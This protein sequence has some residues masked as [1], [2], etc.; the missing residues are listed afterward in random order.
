VA[1]NHFIFTWFNGEPELR[2]QYPSLTFNATYDF[3]ARLS[4][5]MVLILLYHFYITIVGRR[6]GR[7]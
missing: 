2:V 4:H 1:R 7:M 5:T 3:L 6:I